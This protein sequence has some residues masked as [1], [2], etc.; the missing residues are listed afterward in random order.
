MKLPLAEM[1]LMSGCWAR[2]RAGLLQNLWQARAV[3]EQ[4]EDPAEICAVRERIR[5]VKELLS[6]DPKKDD[7]DLQ[8]RARQG[9]VLDPATCNP[10]FPEET[11]DDPAFHGRA[12]R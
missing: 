4:T 8:A 9:V 6:I 2:V 11:V 1:D 10:T 12:L 7:Y 3:L 5:F